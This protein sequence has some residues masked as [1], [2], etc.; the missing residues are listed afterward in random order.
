MP[1]TCTAAEAEQ[2]DFI[3]TCFDILMTVLLAVSN[4]RDIPVVE[5]R[6]FAPCTPLG[7]VRCN[8]LR[9]RCYQRRF[10]CVMFSER[11]F[12]ENIEQSAPDK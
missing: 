6:L 8:L 9:L 2:P 1:N 7:S 12:L 5:E 4:Y 11:L 3:I 10:Y